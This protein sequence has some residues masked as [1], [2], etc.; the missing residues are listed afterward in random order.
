MFRGF[1][2]TVAYLPPGVTFHYRDYGFHSLRVGAES[3]APWG[4][5]KC[6]TE[7]FV[8]HGLKCVPSNSFSSVLQVQLKVDKNGFITAGVEVPTMA[9]KQDFKVSPSTTDPIKAVYGLACPLI[10]TVPQF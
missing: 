3:I 7:V 10:L 9:L 6:F 8:D 4:N 2:H 5:T 1:E